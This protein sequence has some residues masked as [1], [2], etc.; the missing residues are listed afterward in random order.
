MDDLTGLV[1]Y[2]TG[3]QACITRPSVFAI[4]PVEYARGHMANTA[5]LV[6]STMTSI[7][8][9]RGIFNIFLVRKDVGLTIEVWQGS[10][11]V[12]HKLWC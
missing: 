9:I 7:T 1:P 2:T 4:C 10:V 6:S 12:A 3:L 5:G 8:G 11:M